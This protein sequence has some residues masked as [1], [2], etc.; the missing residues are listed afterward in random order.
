MYIL[1]YK[2]YHC[3]MGLETLMLGPPA[4]TPPTCQRGTA[5]R[6]SAMHEGLKDTSQLPPPPPPPPAM[7]R[8]FT[9]YDLEKHPGT[10]SGTIMMCIKWKI[11]HLCIPKKPFSLIGQ[12]LLLCISRYNDETHINFFLWCTIC[13][14]VSLPQLPLLCNGCGF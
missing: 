7:I 12:L 1:N 3:M 5:C 2:P 9:Y 11:P 10:N 13:S 8:R 14:T 6:H 4:K